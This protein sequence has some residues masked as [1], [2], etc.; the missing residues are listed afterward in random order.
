MT[1]SNVLPQNLSTTMSGT[2]AVSAT[3]TAC[4]DA[5]V[6][7][8]GTNPTNWTY[9]DTPHVNS[10]T[11]ATSPA[12][13]QVTVPAPS[14]T[15]S[16]SSFPVSGGTTS[17]TVSNYFDNETVTYCVDDDTTAC[18][19][20]DRTAPA[21]ATVPATGGTVTTG[22]LVIPSGLSVGSHTLYT[23]GSSGSNP[24]GVT[25][26]VT[27]VTPTITTTAG[28]SSVT[29]GGSADD[30]AT[31]SGGYNATGTITW[32]LYSNS[33]CTGTAVFTTTSGGTV[34]GN[35]T[36]TSGSYSATAAG[37]YT[38]KFSYNG[39]SNNNPVSAC[40]G[41][42]ETLT[43]NKAT[44]SLSTTASTNV[45][46][47][48][49][50]TD[51]ATLSGGY[52][53][54]GTIT[55]TLY[56]PSSSASCTTQVGQVTKSVSSNGSY[57]SPTITPGQAGTY[58]W[59]ANYGG[60][61]N[62]TATTNGCGM[63]GE[64]S[65]LNPVT[66]TIVSTAT[67]AT[68][69]VGGSV[70]DQSVVSVGYNPTGTISWTLY[71][72]ATC[73]GTAVFTTGAPAGTVSGDNTYTSASYSVPTANGSAGTYTWK[74]TYNGDINNNPVTACG[75]TGQTLTVNLALSPSTL[76]SATV[77]TSYTNGS[78]SIT[79]TGGT[80]SYTYSATGLP[81]GLSLSST[82]AFSGT[83]TAGGTFSVTV[84]AKDSASPQNSASSTYSLLV[85][86]PTI[87][88]SPS[89]L[90]SGSVGTAY[91][92]GPI[93]ASGGTSPYAYSY[94]G[95]LPTGLALSSGGSFS[96]T[97]SVA[98]S[99]TFTVK[100]TDSSTGTSSPYSGSQSYTVAINQAPSITSA[101]TTT[102]TASV[103]GSFPVTATGSPTPSISET[104]TLPSGVTLSS[105]GLLSGTTTAA[106][107]YPITITAA[108]GVSPDATQ[109]F[110][111]T[112][113]V[114]TA[115]GSY[116]YSVPAGYATVNFTSCGA[117][118]GGGATIDG[119]TGGT[120]GD[121]ECQ[122]GTI[123]VPPTGTTLN[124]YV[125]NGGAG[126]ST[127]S[128]AIGGTSGDGSGGSGGT[129]TGTATGG[130]GGGGGGA[131]AITH[132]ATDIVVDPGGGGGGGGGGSSTSSGN[133]AAGAKRS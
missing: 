49:S 104:G 22:T 28:P 46:V 76:S 113:N 2:C 41:T 65:V 24:S 96:G 35:N 86:A 15:S 95:T 90:P 19:T 26:S 42:G 14:L 130:G 131:S 126:S 51:S 54:T 91:A 98:G 60:D 92:G 48:Q 119:N 107:V 117:G 33:S 74:V 8:N 124:V 40:G 88:L 34:S 27:K 82:G 114:G 87:T 85:N 37:T 110:T 5:G 52:N 6:V 13:T 133:G 100:A 23:E 57:T 50:V 102:F 32:N 25:F 64:S 7:E 56:G 29:V 78:V 84:T 43:V 16:V 127:T 80:P 101:N 71:K 120:G 72:G 66:P 132:S 47:G 63:S 12:S 109:S 30:Q 53:P 75:G 20:A 9:T 123:T 68:V 108:N 97:P 62:N 58:W 121:G 93:V 77:G 83:P 17:A 79:A 55:Y 10:W 11:A 116:T 39:D 94:T 1:R 111:L 59:I 73:T 118:G 129:N 61:S 115:S 3:G 112:V 106:G 128:G 21:T 4:T 125:G 99:Y 36:Y 89:A 44:S 38:W 81:A 69:A 122:T 105:G 45:S 70:A 31:V 103:A 67:P 18:P